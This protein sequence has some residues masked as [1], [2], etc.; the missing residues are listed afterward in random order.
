MDTEDFN[1]LDSTVQM[2]L[3]IAMH[4]RNEMENFHSEQLSDEQMR[5]LNPII[6]Q[7]TYDILNYLK[8]ASNKE[9]SS[10]K[11]IAQGVINFLIQSIPNYWELPNESNPV[12]RLRNLS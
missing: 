9:N 8:L 3:V 10:E 12:I 2:S 5:E 6:R 1:K 7:A 11:I 4:I